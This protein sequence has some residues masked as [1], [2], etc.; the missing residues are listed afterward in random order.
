MRVTARGL[1]L[2]RAQA[3]EDLVVPGDSS[4]AQWPSGDDFQSLGEKYVGE[5]IR[6]VLVP[7]LYGA[8]GSNRAPDTSS[9]QIERYRNTLFARYPAPE[10]EITVREPIT[11]QYGVYASGSGS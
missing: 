2:G 4:G 7:V 6:L 11:W 9:S 5:Q 8:D 10:V 1:L 3:D